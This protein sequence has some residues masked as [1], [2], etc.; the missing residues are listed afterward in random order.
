MLQISQSR[1]ARLSGVSRYKICLFERGDGDLNTAELER[2][3]Q[4]VQVETDRIRRIVQ[5]VDAF[6]HAESTVVAG[7]VQ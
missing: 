5:D 1:I 4:A 2:I 6:S 3:R 7:E